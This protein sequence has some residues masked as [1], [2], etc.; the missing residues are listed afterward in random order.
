L[1]LRKESTRLLRLPDDQAH[2]LALTYSPGL[3]AVFLDGVQVLDS[4]H[5]Q[6]D[7]FHWKPRPLTFG[8]GSRGGQSWRGTLEGV[9]LYHR[10]LAP[11]E[12][13]ENALRYRTRVEARPA[14]G[15]LEAFATLRA[16]STIPTLDEISPYRQALVV[17]D[18]EIDRT[19]EGG[20]ERGAVRVAHWA[21]LDRKLQPATERTT[22]QHYRL[23]L[24]PFDGNPQL[25]AQYVADTLPER[26]DLELFYDLGR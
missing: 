3:L 10:V 20:L 12:I 14:V 19:I 18:Y 26:H 8:A 7:F 5:L 1:R 21:F 25:E 17:F 13:K 22:G 23:Q 16:R 4:R 15:Y 11:D 6:S 2:H 24:E 9:T